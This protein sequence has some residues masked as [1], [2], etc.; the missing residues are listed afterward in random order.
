MVS[1]KIKIVSK[2]V[3]QRQ[4]KMNILDLEAKNSTRTFNEC[5][6]NSIWR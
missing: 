5:S 2:T 3:Y 1:N 4:S 6:N